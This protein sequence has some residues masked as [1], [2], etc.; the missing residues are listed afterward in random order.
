MNR[1]NT[2]VLPSTVAEA[3][4]RHLFPGDGLEAAA[5]LLCSHVGTRRAKLLAREIIP[6]PHHLCERSRDFISWPGE[7]VEEAIDR[8]SVRGD[9]VIAMHSHPGGLFAFSK[10]DDDSDR[11]LLPALHHG[12]DRIAGSAI[13][14]PGGAVRARLYNSQGSFD[15]ID[16]V[17]M[18]DA[19]SIA[20]WR[21]DD[22]SSGPLAIPLP[23]TSGMRAWLSGLSV[24]V[25]GVSGTGSIV[26]EQLARLGVGEII[27]IDF[28]KLEER[29][30]NRILN[31][32]RADIEVHKVEMFA[33]AIRRYSSECHVILSRP[34]SRPGTRFWPPPKQISFFHAWIP[35]KA[36]T[37]PIA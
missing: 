21:P 35:Q 22:G 36:V 10:A 7:W 8:A 34:R 27:L 6:V 26:A 25:V 5:L 33:N 18:S 14:V 23:F 17:M 2:L 32:T 37:L 12:T 1:Q 3:L 30:L 16:L 28:D 11:T 13:M 24:C 19:N 4:R 20:C 31:S 29:N 15:A 9:V